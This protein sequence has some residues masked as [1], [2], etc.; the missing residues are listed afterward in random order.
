[1]IPD[2][3]YDVGM[4]HGNDTAYYLSR[5]FRVVAV[6][7][8][9]SLVARAT[10]RFASEIADGRVTI[11]PV[12]LAPEAGSITFWVNED[13]DEFSSID[14]EAGCRNNTRCHAIPV[15]TKPFGEVLTEYGIPFY[16][17]LDIERGESVCLS[18]IDPADRPRYVSVEAQSLEYLSMLHGLGYNAFKCIDQSTHNY[19]PSALTNERIDHRMLRRWQ[20][21]KQRLARHTGRVPISPVGYR[22]PLASSGPF[23]EDTPGPWRS[24]EDVAYDWLHFKMGNQQRGSLNPFGWYDFHATTMDPGQ[25]AEQPPRA[26]EPVS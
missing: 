9:P 1:M 15:P 24:F 5:G 20:W 11:V 19:P 16:M 12:A 23:G 18:A 8:D 26:T 22:F 3:I 6:E 13:N 4:H 10:K 21:Y 25:A 7:A 14:R 17:K 2:L